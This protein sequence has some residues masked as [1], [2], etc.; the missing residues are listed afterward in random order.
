MRHRK[1]FYFTRREFLKVAGGATAA[2]ATAPLLG[3]CGGGGAASGPIKIGV[4][5]PYSDIYA[6]LGESITDAMRMYFDEI[7]NE[8]GGRPIEIITEDTEIKPDVAQQK[9]RKLIEQDEVDFVTGVVSSGVLMGLRDYFVETQKLLI[10]SNA[11]VNAVSRGAKT[12]YIWRTSFT[13]WMAPWS[14]GGW[15]AENVGTRAVIS[16]PDYAAGQ[17]N[18]NAFSNSYQAAGGEIVS[19]QKTPFPNM[20]DPAPF[21]A[22]L[23]DSGADLVYS[24]YSGGAAVTFVQAY[25]DFGL[26]GQLPLLCAGFMVEQDVLPAQGQAALGTYS[27][28]HWA[29]LLDNPENQTF[30]A[31]FQEKVGREADVF[32]VQGYD[33]AR[34]IVEMLNAVQ[35]DTTN[36]D[37]MIVSLSGISFASPRGPFTLDPNSQAP[38]H[39]MY[40]REVQEVDGALNNVVID[41]FGEIVD[42]GTDDMG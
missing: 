7:G 8:A 32:A 12:P 3:A 9:A 22:E 14:I 30:T 20:G 19:V 24:F 36:V 40:L 13:N 4:L 21:M 15:A 39:N 1:N 5:L 6:V 18:I 37:N 33:T 11:G 38:K 25:S 16:V 29:Q 10:C 23:A 41:N 27:S 31:A 26:S 34:V 28:L 35:G 2:L 17:D 42:P